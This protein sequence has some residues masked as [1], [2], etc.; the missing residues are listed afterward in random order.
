MRRWG[1]LFYQPCLPIGEDGRRITGS[2]EHI[3]LSKKAASEGM[4]LLK[5]EDQVLPLKKGSKI[6]LFGKGCVD[7]VKG[8]GGS[9]DVTTAYVR[10]LAEGMK[11]KVL[12]GKLL[13]YEPLIDYYQK[14]VGAQ[15]AAGIVPGMVKEPK[16]PEEL[17]QEARAFTETAVISISRFSGE[18][19]DR[20]AEQENVKREGEGYEFGMMDRAK[21]LFERGDFYLSKAEQQMV[22]QVKECFEKVIV[23]LNT[24]GVIDSEWFRE[25]DRIQSVLMAWQ[26]GMEGGLA[27]AELLLGEENPSGRLTDTFAKKLTDYPFSEHFHDSESYVEYKEDIYVGYRYFATIP[28][29]AERVN[30]PFGYGLS[31]TEFLI[32]EKSASA[33]EEKLHVCCRVTNTGRYAGKEVVQLYV[34]APQGKLGKPARELKAY[35]K[36]RMLK[37]GESQ[38]LF[39]DVSLEMM[40]SYDDLGKVQKSAYILEEGDYRLWLGNNVRDAKC[41]EFSWH[42]EE[43]RI[44][45]QASPK[46]V[47]NRLSE[48]MLSDGTMEALP[49]NGRLERI[50]EWEP[51]CCAKY[52]EVPAR[53]SV[54]WIFESPYT[55]FDEVA[56]GK[57]TLDD[58]MERLSND[59]LIHLVGGQ[60]N[61][62]V[63]NVFGMGDLPNRGIPN[64]PT[65]DGPAGL[66]L[67]PECGICTTAFPCATLLA[68]TWDEELIEAVGRAGAREVLEN[69]LAIWL[70][71][72]INIHRNPL[73]GRNFEYY[74]EDPYL[75]GKCA[76]AM[77]R[78]IQS[79]GICACVKHFAA[80]NKETNRNDSDSRVSER[81]LREIYLRGFEL[82][83]K[84]ADPWMIMTSY[85]IL[86][87]R[88][89]SEDQELIMGIL[90]EEW[91]YEGVVTT[92]WW[93]H[94][95]Q[96]LEMKAGSDVKMGCGYPKRLKKDLEEGRITR[97]ELSSGA[98]HVLQMILK[99]SAGWKGE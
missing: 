99:L 44:V 20:M 69:N 76:A 97:E 31:Y 58:F 38:E 10:S 74:S 83:V 9:G 30:Y 90:R 48:R 56:D 68:A 16:L 47:P 26:G 96:S 94:G 65:A 43:N 46:C 37:P 34:E 54:P 12:E 42:L 7:Y 82:A 57:C 59:E 14:E 17:L 27:A 72:A 92:D 60:D 75:T 11:Q 3:A 88:R 21:E 51:E 64:A 77:V 45:K 73:A 39:L 24:G 93:N 61:K 36:T 32:E 19:W 79:Q 2:K 5:N 86:N 23:V 55:E 53:E 81:A 22:D 70:T 13:L 89:A 84:E 62:G 78:G 28:G 41:M 33:D 95:E 50:S 4:V 18:G 67:K 15:Y 98:K 66:R 85:N 52:P 87:G 63:A 35:A 25:D 71:P 40:A 91:S 80:N 6:A 49:L 8:G 1:R 29:A